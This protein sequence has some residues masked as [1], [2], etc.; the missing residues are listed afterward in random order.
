MARQ[1][2]SPQGYNLGRDPK[3]TNPFFDL[4]RRGVT[5]TVAVGQVIV[6]TLTAGSDATV[7][8]E[9]SGTETDGVFDFT[10]G[11]PAGPQGPAGA[12]GQDGADG[13]Q[14]PQGETGPQ[15]PAG[16]QGPQGPAGADGL[17]VPAGGTAGQVLEK[18]GDGDN[19]CYWA[20]KNQVDPPNS[21][22]VGMYLKALGEGVYGWATG[23]GGGGGSTVSVTQGVKPD[24]DGGSSGAYEGDII[25]GSIDVDGASTNLY[26]PFVIPS[27]Y[28]YTPDGTILTAVSQYLNTMYLQGIC[29]K[30]YS[31]YGTTKLDAYNGFATCN[32]N[33]FKTAQALNVGYYDNV[34]VKSGGV[35]KP[36]A[37]ELLVFKAGTMGADTD[38]GNVVGRLVIWNNGMSARLV[39][40]DN[41]PADTTLYITGTLGVSHSIYRS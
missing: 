23:G 36:L 15:G 22:Q 26:S 25:I 18:Y 40:T 29:R 12:D 32:C 21:N 31:A 9:N 39:V 8:I 30:Q 5:A 13:A 24:Q 1:P 33:S 37:G 41:I 17:G 27:M 2:L 3:N 16:P 35:V 11:I 20:D 4:I 28:S 38:S 7:S 10:F 34:L 14:G 6:N 19:Q